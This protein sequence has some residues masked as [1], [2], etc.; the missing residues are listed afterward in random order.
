MGRGGVLC[1]QGSPDEALE[2]FGVESYDDI[3]PSLE[4]HDPRDWHRRFT[5]GSPSAAGAERNCARPAQ[6]TSRARG[7]VLYQARVLTSRY[8]RLFMRDRRNMLILLGPARS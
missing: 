8:A 6:R 3:Y 4:E 2:F 7:S 1:F 5:A